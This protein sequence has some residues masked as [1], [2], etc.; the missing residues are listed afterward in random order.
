[1]PDMERYADLPMRESR[2][3]PL[4]LEPAN[5]LRWDIP[6]TIIVQAAI[7]GSFFSRDHNP[8]QPYTPGEILSEAKTSLEK[9]A[10]GVHIHVRDDA[11]IP[12]GDIKRYR[13]VIDPL[14]EEFGDRVLVDGCSAL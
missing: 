5:Q 11:G 7:T 13:A 6:E 4:F 3:G 9:G 1:M 12:T 2:L 10:V 8:R 14:R